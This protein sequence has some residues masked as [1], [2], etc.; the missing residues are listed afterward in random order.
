VAGAVKSTL[1]PEQ[2]DRYEAELRDRARNQRRVTARNLVVQLDRDL[3]L[4][5]DQRERLCESLTSN[6]DESWC[7]Q[8]EVLQNLNNQIYPNIPDQAVV[9]YLNRVQ[10]EI[11][12][13]LRRNGGAYY[14]WGF[15]G[16]VMLDADPLGVEPP[17]EPQKPRGGVAGVLS[18]FQEA[19]M[20][21]PPKPAAP[22]RG[23]AAK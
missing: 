18:R 15:M 6:W 10:R 8:L 14:G 2:A 3:A 4:T 13:G 21:S 12:R 16:N 5:E 7:P 20:K 1:T 23:A 11:W 17:P 19:L 9:P 22:P